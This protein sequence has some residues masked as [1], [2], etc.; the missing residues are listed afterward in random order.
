VS[1]HAHSVNFV[2][3]CTEVKLDS[4]IDEGQDLASKGLVGPHLLGIKDLVFTDVGAPVPK[5]L[6]DGGV[7]A[8]N[9]G[10]DDCKCAHKLAEL[11]F[12]M[13][14]A[15]LDFGA[16]GNIGVRQALAFRALRSKAGQPD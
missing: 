2:Q 13:G 16:V 14:N 12:I 11:V 5:Y 1:S 9:Y 4:P 15:E 7:W 8:E 10:E 3:A 6:A